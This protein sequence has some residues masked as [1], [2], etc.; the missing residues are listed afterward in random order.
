MMN[1]FKNR[2]KH[3]G[4]VITAGLMIFL[5]SARSHADLIT[6]PSTSFE[7]FLVP[8][9]GFESIQFHSIITAAKGEDTI[10]GYF[11]TGAPDGTGSFDNGDGTFT[12]IVNHEIP[13]I[14]SFSVPF[15]LSL[16]LPSFE[17]EQPVLRHGGKGAHIS[18]FVVNR[19][20][21]PTAPLKVLS[22]EEVIDTVSLWDPGAGA[23]VNS[24]NEN[25]QVLCSANLA[26]ESAFFDSAS[27]KGSQIKLYLTGEEFPP[28]DVAAS[29]AEETGQSRA[30]VV[31]LVPDAEFTR[32]DGGRPFAVLLDG[33]EAGAAF[34]LAA[35]GNMNF[36]NL[37]ASPYEQIK[38]VVMISDDENP[39][40]VYLYVGEKT[41]DGPLEIDKAGLTNG[42]LYGLSVNGQLEETGVVS[43]DA[44]SFEDLGDVKAI[45]W[46][47]IEAMSDA[48]SVTRFSK[49]EDLAWDTQD[50]NR[51]YFATS[52]GATRARLWR[53]TLDD[54]TNPTLGGSIEIL[55]DEGADPA[56]NYN[57]FDN[58]A[59]DFEGDVFVQEDGG[60]GPDGLSRMWRYDS[61]EETMT[62]IAHHNPL[63]F[64]ADGQS[65]FITSRG[66]SSGILDLSEVLGRG[67][68]LLT[69]MAHATPEGSEPLDRLRAFE[70]DPPF[71]EEGQL[72]L[73]FIPQPVVSGINLRLGF[74]GSH[75]LSFQK[76]A[77]F[78]YQAQRSTT[79]DDW[80]NLGVPILDD[81]S[82]G[83]ERIDLAANADPNEYFRIVKT[84]R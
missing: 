53:V 16:A 15:P 8:A 30:Q 69:S 63:Y 68:Y 1:L 71:Y 42:N 10:G 24:A 32:L 62:V 28:F 77:G 44:I 46:D 84:A 41:S 61:S 35:L 3:L 22:G 81:G 40:Q 50:A 45:D 25:F 54:I 34:E 75:F 38:T 51:L 37:V 33:P 9:A 57:G 59:C 66:E 79:L 29:I 67:W 19:P 11:L 55:V 14:P 23:Y 13:Y 17:N 83:V 7:P 64:K 52:G 31:A 73:M 47:E 80:A 72:M 49:P 56:A 39:G 6:G 18:R 82:I 21:H 36:E 48:K 12:I 58:I 60:A 4:T 74:D 43:G 78:D 65:E 76:E 70:F 27:G 2:E 20:D 26:P 5:S